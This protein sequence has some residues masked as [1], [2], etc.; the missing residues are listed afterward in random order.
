VVRLHLVFLWRD[1]LLDIEDARFHR[2][3][4][5]PA[6]PRIGELIDIEM[7][8]HSRVEDVMWRSDGVP[9]VALEQAPDAWAHDNSDS[10]QGYLVKCGWTKIPVGRFLYGMWPTD[11]QA[12]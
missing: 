5:W 4:D 7:M 1:P 8:L 2:E 12:D 3:V 10:V 9:C 11:T 6:V